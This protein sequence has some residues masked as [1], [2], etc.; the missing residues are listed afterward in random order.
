MLAAGIRGFLEAA[1]DT[2]QGFSDVAHTLADCHVV[3]RKAIRGD[4]GDGLALAPQLENKLIHFAYARKLKAGDGPT[5]HSAATAKDVM[6]SL[7]ESAPEAVDVYGALCQYTHPAAPSIFRFAGDIAHADTVV[8]DP[9]AGPERI[10]ELVGL[11]RCVGGVALA[12]GVAP[13]VMTVKVLNCFGL[14]AVATPWADGVSLEFSGV[15]RTLE[16]RLQD[17]A[18]PKT[19]TEAE[20]AALIAELNAQYRPFGEPRHRS[21]RRR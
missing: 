20:Q 4:F 5:L 12:L 21:R 3:V 19:A 15:W 16:Q 2:W 10:R 17:P 1:A 8:F 13:L 14:E 6:S 18:G 7:L 9:A 11:S